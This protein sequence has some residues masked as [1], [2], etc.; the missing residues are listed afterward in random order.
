MND[1]P[2]RR[3]I[4]D[5]HIWKAY[6]RRRYAVL[7]YS[8][9]LMLVLTPIAAALGLPQNM[10]R[11]FCGFALVAAVMPNETGRNRYLL[12]A[13][14][15]IIVIVRFASERDDVP[16][17]PGS[18]LGLYGAIGLLAAAAALKTVVTSRGVS[19]EVVYA[20]LST[21]L[22]A[23]IFFGQLHLAVETYWPGSYGGPSPFTEVSSLYFS[24]VT[25]ATLGY[26]DFLPKS[27][28]ARG[29][30]VFEVIGGQLYLGVMV[31]RLIGLF[32]TARD[33]P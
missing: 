33:D 31:A 9:L 13:V 2:A 19:T 7:F 5:H 23:G 25:L 6:E 21:Y 30:T 22:L 26:G 18:M 27:D 10:I 16:I 11:L 32:P 12:L 20:A 14:I 28:L 4:R 8:L 17:S 1:S 15:V 24:F 3:P 29:L